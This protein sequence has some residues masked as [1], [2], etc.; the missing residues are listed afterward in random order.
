MK[1]KE[2]RKKEVIQESYSLSLK[3]SFKSMLHCSV[4]MCL[5]GPECHRHCPVLV[6]LQRFFF[7]LF[8]VYTRQGVLETVGP[9]LRGKGCRRFNS[10]AFV[11]CLC[12][13]LCICI[14]ICLCKCICFYFLIAEELTDKLTRPH[15]GV[16]NSSNARNVLSPTWVAAKPDEAA[17]DY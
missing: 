8:G 6:P 3:Q 1:E 10:C 5:C 17:V 11:F 7:F 12:L 15:N 14:C 13:C 2:E 4:C 16:L 9:Q